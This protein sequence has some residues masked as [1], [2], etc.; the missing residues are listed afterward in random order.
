[1]SARPGDERLPELW[2]RWREEGDVSARDALVSRYLPLVRVTVRLIALGGMTPE[3][4]QD[5]ECCVRLRLLKVVEDYDPSRCRFENY[6]IR[7]LRGAA[8]EFLRQNL[9]ESVYA[10]KE[11]K[12]QGKPLIVPRLYSSTEMS[13]LTE[14]VVDPS[15]GPEELVIE[16]M[17]RDR[18]YRQIERLCPRERHI[19]E[20]IYLRGMSYAASGRL[21]GVS[22]QAVSD[23]L[24]R[25]A[26]HIREALSREKP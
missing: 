17:N 22:G 3:D 9:W 4:R 5:M 7:C 16:L 26:K 8:F 20:D 15:P 2:Q 21:R 24:Q 14:N 13:D 6:A 23:I 11:A 1:M 12:R 10:Q 18:L 25:G 19:M